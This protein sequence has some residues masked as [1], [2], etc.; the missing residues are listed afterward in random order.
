MKG[1]VWS[2]RGG[3]VEANPTN[4]PEDTGSIP[5]L[6]QWVKDPALPCALAQLGFRI[7]VA[8]V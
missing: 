7:A 2:S 3:S 8:V 1:K 6:T 5:D 4:I